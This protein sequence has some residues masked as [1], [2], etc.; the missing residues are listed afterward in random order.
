MSCRRLT[1]LIKQ[2]FRV[3]QLYKWFATKTC[4]EHW[5]TRIMVRLSFGVRF[6]RML[7]PRGAGQKT[8]KNG[9]GVRKILHRRSWRINTTEKHWFSRRSQWDHSRA[10]GTDRGTGKQGLGVAE[11]I[12]PKVWTSE[13]EVGGARPTG[14]LVC[15]NARSKFKLKSIQWVWC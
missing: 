2:H 4:F 15:A 12:P 9:F 6:S 13:S 14:K 11:F 5:N 3:L 8:C 1:E 10:L 7:S